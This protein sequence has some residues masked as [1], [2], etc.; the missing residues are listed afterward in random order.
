MEIINLI[1][2]KKLT[3]KKVVWPSIMTGAIY[4]FTK[5]HKTNF[6]WMLLWICVMFVWYYCYY[7]H[8][9]VDDANEI[10]ICFLGIE[11]GDYYPLIY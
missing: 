4:N 5:I 8:D 11:E 10:Q 9:C 6:I 7:C 3:S 1:K 2:E